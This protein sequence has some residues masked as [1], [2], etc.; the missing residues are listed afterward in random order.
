MRKKKSIKKEL[1]AINE[2]LCD[3]R[4]SLEYLEDIKIRIMV[5]ETGVKLINMSLPIV[6]QGSGPEQV[7]ESK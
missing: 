3:I 2:S 6:Y 5:L 1:Q 4:R 7:P